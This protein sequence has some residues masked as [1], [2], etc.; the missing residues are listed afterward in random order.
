MDG[1]ALQKHLS[2]I[3][4][5]PDLLQMA[6]EFGVVE[7]DSQLD[8]AGFLIALV[9]CG[10]THEGGR[11]RDVLRAYLEQGYGRV[12]RSAFYARF[13][14][15]LEALL[16]ALLHRA[17]VAGQ[18]QE[19]LLPGILEGVSDWRIFDSETIK[20]PKGAQA[21]YPGCGDYAALKIHK[22]FS[23]GKGNLVDYQFSPA[24]EHDSP[25]LVVDEARRGQGLLFGLVYVSLARLAACAQHGV[26]YVCR[27]KSNWKPSV[28][29]LV[30]GTVTEPLEGEID[31]DLLLAEDI[32]VCEDKA[33]DADVTLGRGALRVRSRLV[34]VPTEK[35]YCFFLTSLSRHRR[36]PLQIGQIYRCRWDIEI[37]NKVDKEGARLDEVTATKG[38]SIRTLLLASLLNATIARAI[39]QSEKLALRRGKAAHQPADRAPL[40]AIAL[41]KA[42]AA[43]H[44]SITRLLM[45]ETATRWDWAKVM[46]R[47]RTLSKDGN[48]RRRPSVLDTIQGLT[49]PPAPRRVKG[50]KLAS[51]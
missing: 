36:G 6:T 26:H 24:R 33:I 29:R 47:L 11:Q 31:F 14:A 2:R 40:H 27:L 48:W 28:T 7:R 43:F 44:P 3:L 19:T 9:L 25:F 45:V 35:G 49:A 51:A 16:A 21:E 42:L 38:T 1:E 20:L 4:H 32:L 15:A 12:E 17:V 5:V 23:L 10:G 30:R 22:E 37:D 13:N 41:M 8:V 18:A 34:G 50:K 39:V 46:S